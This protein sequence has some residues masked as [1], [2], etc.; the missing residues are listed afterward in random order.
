MAKLENLID[1]QLLGAYHDE[2][3][4]NG[5]KILG[6]VESLSL[7]G[8]YAKNSIINCAGV[9]YISTAAVTGLPTN[10]VTHNGQ[11]VTDNGEVVVH[12][13]NTETKWKKLAGR[14]VDNSPIENSDSLITSGGV[15]AALSH[16]LTIIAAQQ[17]EITQQELHF[18]D[19]T[20]I[21]EIG[22]ETNV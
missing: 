5:Y 8:S 6:D 11:M 18:N 7:S 14:T 22:E 13:E 1:T 21:I 3:M 4:K 2:L 16:L 17:E 15:F 19:E 12:G 20:G 10:I 9:I